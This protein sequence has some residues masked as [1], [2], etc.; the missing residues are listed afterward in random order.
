MNSISKDMILQLV[1]ERGSWF[2]SLYMPTQPAGREMAQNRIRF[3]N[4]LEAAKAK[5]T[6][7]GMNASDATLLLAEATELLEQPSLWQSSA[8]GL[9]VLISEAGT[10]VYH[11]PFSCEELCV[12]S[13]RFHIVPLL[14]WQQRE[15][16]Y[17]LLTLS[18]NHVR[19]FSGT[20][21]SLEQMTAPELPKSKAET[22]HHEKPE[23]A[24]QVHSGQPQ[25]RGKEGLVFTGHGGKADVSNP[26]L[27]AFCRAVGEA[28][29]EALKLR[30]EPLVVACVDHLFAIYHR[31]NK[32]PHLLKKH[33]PG[34]VDHVSLEELRQCAWSLAESLKAEQEKAAIEKYWNVE[35]QGRNCNRL[36]Q[37]LPAAAAGEVET[38]FIDPKLRRMGA[39]D[40]QSND[41]HFDEG[42]PESRSEDLVNLAACLVLEHRG[43]VDAISSGNLPGGGT[44]AATLR[45]PTNVT[46]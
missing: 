32:Y 14:A 23:G 34:N 9:A 40:A 22:L 44:L 5:L 31:H 46:A 10:R 12:V 45:Y 29:G 19:L 15:A 18:E 35:H 28:V 6:D 11:L 43:S 13:G 41:V 7:R 20:D 4:L 26:E 17:Y 3:R 8:H 24:Y 25:F 42:K 33:I 30:T 38:L 1:K 2:V 16:S 37:V 27:S 39:F 21:N 36:E